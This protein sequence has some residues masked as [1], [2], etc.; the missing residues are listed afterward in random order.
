MAWVG[1]EP[2]T[3]RCQSSTLPT[4]PRGYLDKRCIPLSSISFL[5]AKQRPSC[6]PRK[7]AMSLIYGPPAECNISLH[8]CLYY[9]RGEKNEHTWIPLHTTVVLEYRLNNQVFW[10]LTFVEVTVI[11]STG[12]HKTN[13]N[14]ISIQ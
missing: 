4:I 9:T 12:T 11:R 3:F 14:L 13:R 1:I 7:V 2:L 5:A 8:S 6:Y 10:R